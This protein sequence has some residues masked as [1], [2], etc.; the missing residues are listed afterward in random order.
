LDVTDFKTFRAGRTANL[1]HRSIVS[2]GCASGLLLYATLLCAIFAAPARAAEK[3]ALNPDEP[4]P[5][6]TSSHVSATIEFALPA[7]AEAIGR[8][9]PRR[10]ATFN[11]RVNCVHRRVLFFKVNANCDIS[12][13]VEREGPVSLYGKGDRLFGAVAIFGTVAG[14][15]AN[16]FTSRIHGNAEARATVDAEA[17]PELRHD[18]SL[19]LHFSDGFH[20]NEPPYLHVLG[21]DIALAR[22]VEPRIRTQLGRVRARALAAARALDLHGKAESA[23]RRAFEPIKLADDPEIWLQLTP[24]SAAFA[25]VRANARVMEGSLEIQGN[26]ETFVGHAP[27]AVTATPLAPLGKDVT[28]PGKFEIML[29]VHID[30]ETLSQKIKQTIA[31]AAPQSAAILRDIK[32]YPSAGKLVV[33]LRIA[34]SEETDP[35][36]GD[37]FYLSATPHLDGDSQTLRLPDLGAAADNANAL[38]KLLGND[39]LVDTLRQ[40]VSVSYQDAAQKLIAAA[41]EKLTRP[42]KNGFRMEGRLASATLDKVLLL[43]GGLSVQLRASGDLK[44]LYGL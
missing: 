12:G 22:F 15:G 5:L 26:A 42:L 20:W 25:G 3:P 28:A 35:N 2:P 9:I 43:A 1:P 29:P 31:A 11:E 8:D 37:W 36:A 41:N 14:Q 6:V 24:Q 23:W 4:A 16:R 44:I 21:H 13:Y 7:L 30:Y 17:R 27:P 18:W 40:Q 34:K 39:G 10:L 38:G 19:D 32:I 33:G